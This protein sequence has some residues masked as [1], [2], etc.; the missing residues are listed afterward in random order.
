MAWYAA[1]RR[2]PRP[3]PER[4]VELVPEGIADVLSVLR[5]STVLLDASD[6]V[7]RASPTAYA[8]GLV[9][10]DRLASPEI[11]ALVR[12]VRRDGEIRQQDLELPRGPLGGETL[13]VTARVAPLADGDLVLVLVEDRTESR[14][15]DAVRRDFVA[16][17][18]HELKTPVGALSLL[19]EAVIGASDDPEAV[20]R[21]AQR[22]HREAARLSDLVQELID[23][24]RLQG[25]DPLKAARRVEV[26]G[27]VVEAVDRCS[28]AAGAKSITLVTGGEEG[29]CVIGDEQQLVMALRNLIDNAISYSPEKTRVAVAVRHRGDLVELSVTDQG[30]GIPEADLDRIFE[31]FYRV[32]PARSRE[33][34][35]TGLGLSIVKHIATNHGGEVSVWS[36]EGSGSTF[37]IRLPQDATTRGD[38]DPLVAAEAAALNEHG[39]PDAPLAPTPRPVSQEAQ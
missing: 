26:D 10:S 11:L 13:A 12:R 7:L 38:D 2:R 25:H 14:R 31:R 4:P 29:L 6:D 33:T 32:D 17:V 16:N 22:M 35:G 19:A 15:V 9:R 23:L 5:S 30:I 24:S 18:S 3:Q 28:L 37:T 21:F 39:A 1:G 27:V 20:R 34:G 36:A 8:F